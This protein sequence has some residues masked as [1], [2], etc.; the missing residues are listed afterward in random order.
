MQIIE[1]GYGGINDPI[2]KLEIASSLRSAIEY[3]TELTIDEH[4]SGKLNK[5]ADEAWKKI[6][7]LINQLTGEN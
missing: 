4:L 1:D 7:K 5:D 3:Y 2:D 6:E